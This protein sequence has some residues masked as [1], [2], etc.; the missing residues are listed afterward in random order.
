MS[1]TRELL[2]RIGGMTYVTALNQI[3]SY[4]TLTMSER[5]LKYLTIILPW[6]KYRYKK[7]PMGLLNSA[8]VFQRE[9]K[10]L[11]QGLEYVMVY[12]DN[13]LV[14]TKGDYNDHLNKIRTML[15]RMK[16]KWIQL[17]PKK[18]FSARRRW[19][20]LVT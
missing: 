5:S 18:S 11:F 15:E 9:M 17:E 4:Y 14:V 1:A 7:M 2:H 6:D 13:V 16:S 3:L 8:D 20:I 19:N 12:I 10:K